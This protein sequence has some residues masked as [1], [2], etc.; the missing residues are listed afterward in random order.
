MKF[1]E[2]QQ[3]LISAGKLVLLEESNAFMKK[4]VE[5]LL[6]VSQ[7]LGLG[8]KIMKPEQKRYSFVVTGIQDKIILKRQL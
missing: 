7:K 4:S 6:E 5:G 8:M 2:R 1:N 3:G